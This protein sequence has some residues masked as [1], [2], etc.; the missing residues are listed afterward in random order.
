[1][2]AEDDQQP[3]FKIKKR[4]PN[5]ARSSLNRS[6][7]SAS[8]NSAA[9]AASPAKL[10]FDQSAGGEGEDEDDGGAA[11]VQS[12]FK[13]KT[14]AG[15]VREREGGGAGKGKS[16]LSFGASA[17]E[18]EDDDD[19]AV[20]RS[21][22]PSSTPKRALLRAA[23]P[24]SSSTASL[25]DAAASPVGAA[26]SGSYSKD[27]LEQL[28]RE[29]RSTPRAFGS[30][31]EAGGGTGGYDS[32]TRSKFGEEQLQDESLIPTTDAIARAKARR[33]E[34]R[35]AGPSASSAG[36]DYVS[37]DVGFASKGGESRLVREEDEIG[38]GD[39]DLAAFTDATTTLPLGKK[40][41]KAAA[42]KLR[43]EMGEMIDDVAM[44]VEEEDEEMRE[45]EKAQIRRAGGGGEMTRRREDGVRGDGKKVSY[46]AAPIPQSAPL[47][48][49]TSAL[50]RLTSQLSSLQTLHTSD[51]VALSH[52]AS[53]KADLD[54]QEQELREAVEKTE[55]KGKWFEEMKGEVEDWAAFLEEKFPKLEE[56]ESSS[57]ALLRERYRI[58]ASRR[59]EQFSDDVSLFTGQPVP[60]LF[61]PKLL[62]SDDA[63]EGEDAAMQDEQDEDKENEEDLLPRSSA[64]QSRRSS[65]PS[66]SLPSSSLPP[67]SS[68][69][70]KTAV[71]E[72]HF[73]LT[74]L[75]SDVLTRAFRDPNLG[76]RQK[77]EEWRELWR[78]EYEM[79]F[80][81]LGMVQ[82]W[83]F[84]ARV[85][86]VGGWNPLEIEELP[87][88]PPDL[89]S[90]AWHRALSAYSHPPQSPSHSSHEEDADES[91]ELIN[92]LVASV[93][94]PR[95]SALAR[96]AYDPYDER[97]TRAAVK[98]V[99]EVSYCVEPSSPKFEALVL[100]FMHR[101]R[102]SIAHLQTLLLPSIST[103]SLSL[104]SLAFD[105]STF[106]SRTQF[107]ASLLP[108]LSACQ[109][110]RRF[111]RALRGPS[112]P[113]QLSK[114]EAR[115]GGVL[116]VG[117]G[118]TFDE[119]VQRELVGRV[120]LPVVE[121]AWGTGGEEVAPK[122][123]ELLP[124]DIPPALRRRLEGAEVQR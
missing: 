73:S 75:F 103:S 6:A 88:S 119:L 116:E 66:P 117:K 48:S 24:P 35:K 16:R 86:V 70:L 45:W 101:L 2:D 122:I 80:A 113:V 95:L 84:W 94:L 51:T 81:G 43:Q 55:R 63:Q 49:L 8:L 89:S 108:L 18:G 124:K 46:R 59:I 40:A 72:Q 53:E 4:N 31:E 26:T 92:S 123:L 38:D 97:M 17:D 107:L 37:L 1:M 41:N 27:Y 12:R 32:L 36:G 65:R 20:K 93:L 58:I 96:A 50:S 112:V 67:S 91:T 10:S 79:T 30:T 3:V 69:D 115:G 118:G 87:S 33:E 34:L 76:I 114:E 71:T 19:S 44:D 9:A 5:K 54:R 52:F 82:V 56:I 39:E 11:V 100:A 29:Q 74:A 90:Y 25:V 42:L 13:K 98:W 47:P 99:D 28:K 83:E 15:R 68:S 77:F 102:L 64:R 7:S 121:A 105:P 78:E 14:P 60:T 110:W 62:P 21:S 22:T 120:V 104:P 61:P 111:M 57:L 85:E 23:L 106:T 109:K